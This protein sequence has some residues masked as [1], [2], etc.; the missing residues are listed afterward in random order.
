MNEQPFL[1]RLW[2]TISLIAVTVAPIVFTLCAIWLNQPFRWLLTTVTIIAFSIFN[3]A[4]LKASIK[5]ATG[6]EIADV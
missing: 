4:L 3:L 6:Q 5:P 1:I 2:T